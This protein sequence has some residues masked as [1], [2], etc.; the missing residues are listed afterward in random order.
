MS[1]A[2]LGWMEGEQR[3]FE[4]AQ[5]SRPSKLAARGFGHFFPLRLRA[6]DVGRTDMPQALA[7]KRLP[8]AKLKSLFNAFAKR[9]EEGD[10]LESCAVGTV[11]LGLGLDADL[12]HLRAAPAAVFSDW[13]A[14]IARHF[15]LGD[16]RRTASFA[17]LVLT[18]IEGAYVR[19]RV[20][21]SSRAFEEAGAWLAELVEPRAAPAALRPLTIGT[22]PS[23]KGRVTPA[24]PGRRVARRPRTWLR[25][26]MRTW[27]AF[28][29]GT[30]R[31]DGLPGTGRSSPESRCFLRSV[32]GEFDATRRDRGSVLRFDSTTRMQRHGCR[33]SLR[34]GSCPWV[35]CLLRVTERAPRVWLLIRLPPPHES[36]AAS[37]ADETPDRS[38]RSRRRTPLF[39][40]L[41][42][43]SPQE[44][45]P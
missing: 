2:W 22:Q 14:L 32:K 16:A 4:L 5:Q 9:V 28:G 39:P 31:V 20:E 10:Y 24:G 11:G 40:R 13:V 41:P 17:G 12:E 33:A 23:G 26:L 37:D 7:G 1:M 21:H 27:V 35:G 38:L 29:V 43:Q 34:D 42:A 44:R 15:D 3:L 30:C 45:A 25:L 8:R 36:P 18:N 6:V 19:C